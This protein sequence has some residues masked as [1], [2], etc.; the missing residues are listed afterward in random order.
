[1]KKTL[2]FILIVLAT[3]MESQA[4]TTG[5]TTKKLDE[6]LSVKFPYEPKE[7]QAGSFMSLSKDSNIVYIVTIVDFKKNFNVDS[8]AIAPL[9]E[10]PEFAGQ[11]KTGLTT[12]MPKVTLADMVMGKWHGFTSYTTTGV[13]TDKKIYN[14]QMILVGNKMYSFSTIRRDDKYLSDKEYFLKNF[15]VL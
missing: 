6:R 9:K 10:T 12:S 13:D 15:S 5:W 3:V 14:I 7:F 1:M 2:L 11:L 4:Q 8:V